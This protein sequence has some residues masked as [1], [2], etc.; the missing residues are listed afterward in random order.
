MKKYIKVIS[1]GIIVGIM[2]FSC[3][4]TSTEPGPV[5]VE[6]KWEY[7]GPGILSSP[8]MSS[9]G[10]IYAFSE[11]DTLYS[12]NSDGTLKWKY[13]LPDT[14]WYFP[15]NIFVSPV[16]GTDGVIYVFAVDGYLYAI[17]SDGTLK[18]KYPIKTSFPTIY[19]TPAVGSDGTIYAFAPDSLFAINPNGSLKWEIDIGGGNVSVPAIGLDGTIYIGADRDLYA[20]NPDGSVKWSID[21]APAIYVGV[22]LALESDGTLYVL[23]VGGI[24]DAGNILAVNPDGT[25]EWTYQI[26][27]QYFIAMGCPVIGPNGIIYLAGNIGYTG[28]IYAISN[29]GHLQWKVENPGINNQELAT[30]AIDSDGIIYIQEGALN[31]DGTLEW[32]YPLGDIVVSSMGSPVIGSDGTIYVG[33]PTGL[34]AFEGTSQGLASSAWP[35]FQH[36]N[37]NT[38]RIGGQ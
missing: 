32:E 1:F 37:K 21:M 24:D 28:Y 3:K 17:N 13:A 30:F 22:G 31:P 11:N 16:V 15:T 20:I 12:V 10:A 2:F 34:Y 26:E 9:D 33:S 5:Q 18:W 35:R 36:D 38:G 4:K 14:I 25:I 23:G 8:A 19:G 6:F 29:D 27:E 7:E